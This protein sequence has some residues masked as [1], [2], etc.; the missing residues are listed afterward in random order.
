MKKFEIGFIGAGNMAKAILNGILSKNIISPEKIIISDINS[1]NF[2]EFEQIGVK[3]TTDNSLVVKN[4]KYI[5]LAI[6]PQVAMEILPSLKEF[7]HENLFISIMAGIKKDKIKEILGNVSI[8]RIMPNTPCMVGKGMSAIDA[9]DFDKK[10]KSLVFEIFNS[11]GKTIEL[12][13]TYFDSVTSVSGSGP[14]YVYMFINSM[15]KGGI[16]NGLSY[17][18]S[19]ILVLQTFK[20]AI[21]MVESSNDSIE[22]LINNVCSRGGTTIEAV[23]YFR[24]QNLED[25]IIE[26]MNKCKKRSEE[27]SQI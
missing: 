26:G 18:E 27:L 14:A 16:N 19:K 5:I 9:S 4:A 11:L 12:D 8:S 13:E 10:S 17:E 22:T 7:I 15:I 25:L 6:K 1:D 3:C 2:Y 20:G 21:S 24:N 23:N